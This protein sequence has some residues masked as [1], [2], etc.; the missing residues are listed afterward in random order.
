MGMES[1]FG[2]TLRGI[3]WKALLKWVFSGLKGLVMMFVRADMD[4]K[5]KAWGR[6]FGVSESKL[7]N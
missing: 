2:G 4:V 7:D 5:I 6:E 1:M 3:F